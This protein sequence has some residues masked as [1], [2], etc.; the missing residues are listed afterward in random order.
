[1]NIKCRRFKKNSSAFLFFLFVYFSPLLWRGAGG[2]AAAQMFDSIQNAFH[3]KPRLAGLFT[4]KNTFINSFRSPIF[5]MN[6]ELNFN[7]TVAVGAG[8]SWLL[9][10]PPESGKDNTPFYLE[11]TFTDASGV[12]TVYPA[13]RF[14][15]IN[16]FFEY[17]YFRSEEHT[18]EL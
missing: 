18:S 10:S 17:V 2:E 6:A 11:K 3:H 7:R 13:L 4:T 16:F 9:L 5:T 15:Y 12:H 1:M 8:I 14:R